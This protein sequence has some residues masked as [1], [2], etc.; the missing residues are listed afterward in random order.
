M[1]SEWLDNPALLNNETLPLLE[2]MTLEYPASGIVWGLYLKNLFIVTGDQFSD[3]LHNVAIRV[4]DRTWLKALIASK[5][6]ARSRNHSDIYLEI[7]DYQLG[8]DFPSE[9]IV[10]KSDS[11]SMSLI[12]SFLAA[13]ATFARPENIDS[14]SRSKEIVDLAD[15]ISDDIVTEGFA[16]L[17]L[18]QGNLP[19]ALEAFE[20]LS[21]KFP[22]KSIYFAGRIEEIKSLMNQ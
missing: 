10:Q 16:N 2:S 3:K 8:Y 17:L 1:I 18:A 6:K 15:T 13:G 22:E 11:E 7:S 21:F 9:E 19:K 5:T 20:K 14:P 12:D 4:S